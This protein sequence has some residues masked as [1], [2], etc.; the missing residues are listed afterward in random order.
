MVTGLSMP[1][2][3]SI[4]ERIIRFRSTIERLRE[5]IV[6]LPQSDMIR[7]SAL[8][9]FEF[10]YEVC[11]KTLKAIIVHEGVEDPKFPRATFVA[12]LKFGQL[13]TDEPWLSMVEDRNVLVHAYY[14]E[15]ALRV[16]GKINDYLNAFD[17][18]CI[19]IEQRYANPT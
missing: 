2:K 14:E 11:W 15:F 16:H 12:A 7:D 1:P 10:T 5:P 9:R 4:T 8:K 13:T 17:S 6:V 19:R 3:R 18:V